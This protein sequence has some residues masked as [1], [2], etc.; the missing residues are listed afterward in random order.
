MP[1]AAGT[2]FGPYAIQSLLGVGGMGEVYRARD[3]RLGRDVAIKVLPSVWTRSG[4]TALRPRPARLL[5]PNIGAPASEQNTSAE[6][7]RA[8]AGPNVEGNRSGPRA[9]GPRRG[10]R[11]SRSRASC[12][13]AGR[14]PRERHHPPRPETGQCEDH[15]GRSQVVS[16]TSFSRPSQIRR[17]SSCS[18]DCCS[19]IW[20]DWEATDAACAPVS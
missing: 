4:Q 10:R 3:E 7:G 20:F 11:A 16:S 8:G 9:C 6:A 14:G 17:A 2:R 12:R 15:T 5:N 13:G 19:G 1:I 18:T